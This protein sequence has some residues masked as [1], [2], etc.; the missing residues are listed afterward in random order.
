MHDYAVYG[1]NFWKM[2]AHGLSNRNLVS[3]FSLAV[4]RTNSSDLRQKI[5]DVVKLVQH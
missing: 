4:F 3:P 5:V 2:T 1:L